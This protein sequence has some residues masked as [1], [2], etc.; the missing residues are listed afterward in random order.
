MHGLYSTDAL[1]AKLIRLT[2]SQLRVYTDCKQ[3]KSVDGQILVQW[4]VAHSKYCAV[5]LTLAMSCRKQKLQW[6]QDNAFPVPCTEWV[7]AKLLSGFC[8]THGCLQ[9]S[10]KRSIVF[11]NQFD[12][13][14]LL[15]VIG[16][17]LSTA[18]AVCTLLYL[19][20][21]RPIFKCAAQRRQN[22]PLPEMFACH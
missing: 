12:R 3:C 22:L 11:K 15:L 4:V 10:R 21:R 2:L 18:H 9:Q 7:T 13:L 19:R 17:F 16:V 6:S 1:W 20:A 14:N 5:G 8:A